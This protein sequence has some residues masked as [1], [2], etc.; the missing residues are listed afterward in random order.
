[1][2]NKKIIFILLGF[3][4]V[5]IAGISY[6]LFVPDPAETTNKYLSA[7][8][9]NNYKIMYSLLTEESKKNIEFEQFENSYKSFYEKFNLADKNFENLII[10]KQSFNKT[11]A[12]YLSN[13]KSKDFGSKEY[14]QKIKLEREGLVNWK[15]VWDYQ[16]VFPGLTE[17]DK[18]IRKRIFPE[19][20]GIFDRNGKPLAVKGEAVTVGIQ[21]SR[22]KDRNLLLEKLHRLLKIDKKLIS[23]KIDK[24]KEHPDWFVPIKTY[25]MEKYRNLESDLRPIPGVVFRKNEARIYPEGEKAAHLTGYIGEVTNNWIESHPDIDYKIGDIVGRAGI[26]KAFEERLHGK[27]G[28]LLYL[29]KENKDKKLVMKKE[30]VR[31]SDIY[32]T[33]D[34]SYQNKVWQSLSDK[35]GSVIILD[36]K[37]QEIMAL[38]NSPSFNPNL[39]SLG[40][41]TDEWEQIKSDKNN[42]ML[43]R[44]TQGLYA[45]GS[46]FKII[47]ASAALNTDSFSETTEFNDQGKYKVKGN[48][49]R[50]YEDEVFNNHQFT[51]ALVHSINT[52]FGKIGLKVGEKA[53]RQYAVNFGFEEKMNFSLPVSKSSTGNIN[54]EVDLAWTA[55]GQGEVT[56]TPL[57]VSRVISTIARNG[58]KTNPIIIKNKDSNGIY[59]NNAER[60]IIDKKTALSLKDILTRVVEEGTANKAKM[61]EIKVAGK[62]GTAEI[63]DRTENTHAWFAGFAPVNEPRVAIVVFL[64]KGGVGGKDAAPL[65]KNIVSNL[66]IKDKGELNEKK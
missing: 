21:P 40:M 37:T 17:N 2:K 30:A 16:Q 62:T 13:L 18:F 20:G 34:I 8:K 27:A 45:P 65:F 11:K 5:V 31:G 59:T 61:K 26:E 42:P 6:I 47:T 28:Y 23:S 39:F 60:Q 25:T 38:V 52:T 54:S 9:S 35:I 53:L 41:T 55:L 46:V 57:Q 15:I 50:N 51:D 36:P 49:I 7:W 58:K 44:A 32:L 1:M 4:T 19:R 24:Y 12:D 33:V 66:F 48:V 56:A 10:N 14:E 22:I 63:D 3:L 29:K 64:E 43:N